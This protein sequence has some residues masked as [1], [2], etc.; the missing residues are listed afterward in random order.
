ME[1]TTEMMEAYATLMEYREAFY[2]A[3][4]NNLPAEERKYANQLLKYTL[5]NFQEKVPREVRE[6]LSRGNF[7][8][9]QTLEKQARD[10]ENEL[11]VVNLSGLNSMHI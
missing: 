2:S 9:L 11:F 3:S 5:P 8:E 10:A 7:Q 6:R 1:I 4:R